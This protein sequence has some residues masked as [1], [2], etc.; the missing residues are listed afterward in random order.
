M[1]VWDTGTVVGLE[2]FAVA[3]L[4]LG[5]AGMNKERTGNGLTAAGTVLA[6][7]LLLV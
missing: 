4:A 7:V 3:G 6:A 5:I 2:M 1:T